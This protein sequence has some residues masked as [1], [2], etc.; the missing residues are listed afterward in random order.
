LA[1]A[2]LKRLHEQTAE[3]ELVNLARQGDEAAFEEIV[4]RYSP[5]VFRIASQ[6]FRRREA[7]EDAAQ[8]IF[9]KVYTQ[10]DSYEG[11]G[12]LEGW[13]TR[14]ATNTCINTLRSAK[15]RPEAPIAELTEAEDEWLAQKLIDT[16]DSRPSVENHLVA[17]NLAEKLLAM[18]PAEDR[19]VLSLMDGE[20]LSVKEVVDIT[21]WSESKVKMR[22]MRAR[23]RMRQAVEKLFKSKKSLESAGR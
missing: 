22:A 12:S 7:V 2:V 11:R 5:R 9:L 4:Q 21:G 23:Q 3:L 8:E 6:F 19:L 14:I 17:V 18:V 1:G 16:A 20:E 13:I 15:R 10:L